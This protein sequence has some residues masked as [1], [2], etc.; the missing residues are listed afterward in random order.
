MRAE[1]LLRVG[2]EPPA[3]GAVSEPTLSAGTTAVAASSTARPAGAPPCASAVSG[4]PVARLRANGRLVAAVLGSRCR[5]KC[6]P[7]MRAIR[8][9]CGPTHAT[10]AEL[11]V[12]AAPVG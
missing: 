12:I 1:S 4:L 8:P 2:A 11:G 9:P 6:Q 10:S 5:A 3:N 7:L